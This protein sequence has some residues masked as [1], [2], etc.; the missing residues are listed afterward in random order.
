MTPLILFLFTFA[1]YR[2]NSKEK[3]KK[4]ETQLSQSKENQKTKIITKK[5]LIKK[6][7]KK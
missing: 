1:Y 7:I 5:K 6:R 3:V 2:K 4:I